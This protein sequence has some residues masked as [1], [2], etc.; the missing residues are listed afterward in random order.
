[1]KAQ[2]APGPWSINR[3]HVLSTVHGKRYLVANVHNVNFTKEANAANARLIAAAPDLLAALE[4]IIR[5]NDA[6]PGATIG[7][8]VVCQS[9][10]QLARAAIAKATGF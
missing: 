6:P 8:A 10:A 1:M 3:T 7:E 5:A 2:H 4:L 9:Y